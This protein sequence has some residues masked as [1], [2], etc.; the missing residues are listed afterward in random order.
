MGGRIRTGRA[1]SVSFT[2]S[3]SW[4]H[5]DHHS[6]L[7]TT[8]DIQGGTPL[9][10]SWGYWYS[11]SHFGLH[12]LSCLHTKSPSVPHLSTQVSP[13]RDRLHM[14]LFSSPS[15]HSKTMYLTVTSSSGACHSFQM[16]FYWISR[17]TFLPIYQPVP[18][19]VSPRCHPPSPENFILARSMLPYIATSNL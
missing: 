2:A 18:P 5:C 14:P 15:T 16:Y 13:H 12:A 17:G 11:S 1:Q 3:V 8:E 4:A 6:G 19:S 7:Y 10:P 9:R